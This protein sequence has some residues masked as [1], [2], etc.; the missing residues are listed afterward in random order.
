[1][2]LYHTHR[3]Q[4]FSAIIGQKHIIDT[5]ISQIINNKVTHAYLFSGPRGIGKTT[6][7]RILAKSLNCE[8]RKNGK[9]EPC[10]ACESCTQI[11]NS[12]ALDV[13]E[14]DAA[15]H[16]GVDNV[17]TH[18][19]EHS[20]FQPSHSSYKIFIIDEVH[21]LST[22]AF[23]A[24]L[25]II[26]EPPKHV[27]FILA[28]TELHKIPDTIIS[29]CQRFNFEKIEFETLSKHIVS[30]AKKEGTKIDNDVV[31]RIVYKSDGCARDAINFLDQIMASGEKHITSDLASIVLPVANQEHILDLIYALIEKNSVLA[32]DILSKITKAN[33]DIATVFEQTIGSL[34]HIMVTKAQG[35]GMIAGIDIDKDQIKK[36]EEYSL[37]IN[38]ADIILLIDILLK[39][40]QDIRTS[41]IQELPIEMAIIEWCTKEK[42][43]LNYKQ[44]NIESLESTIIPPKELL[45]SSKEDTAKEKIVG[46][47]NNNTIN[48]YQLVHTSESNNEITES[49]I[50]EDWNLVISKIEIDSPSLVFILKMA[51]ILSYSNNSLTISVE[52]P[53]HRDKLQEK[54]CQSKINDIMSSIYKSK[55]NFN[56]VLKNIQ[57]DIKE[58]DTDGLGS[59]ASLVGGQ[60]IS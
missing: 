18:I 30:I 3:P 37:K 9:N 15:S 14:I 57:D 54:N 40:K 47:N 39:R 56:V 46:E 36:I 20:Q 44:E 34:R 2:A 41:P 21:M 22:S 48:K 58:K 52:Y 12:R 59:L 17:R 53:F 33:T 29:R 1:M 4:D 45:P 25:K 16:T 31:K 8:R 42:S 10:N 43:S 38:S 7:A 32:L 24:M 49:K 50:R 6:I 5:L 26:E 60:I 55:I 11:T 51:T 35:S 27:I 19:I 23:N 13:I 28:T